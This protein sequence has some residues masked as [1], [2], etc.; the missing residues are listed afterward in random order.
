MLY[1]F[2]ILYII[3]QLFVMLNILPVLFSYF[4]TPWLREN[5]KKNSVCSQCRQ[6]LEKSIFSM[7]LIEYAN[8]KSTDRWT[9][10]SFYISKMYQ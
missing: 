10:I 3:S 7:W 8:V 9:P 1:I 4:Y 2:Y 6:N 5:D